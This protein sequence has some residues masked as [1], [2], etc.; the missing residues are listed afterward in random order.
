MI[1]S[2]GKAK[3]L[4]YIHVQALERQLVFSGSP[5]VRIVSYEDHLQ[6]SIQIQSNI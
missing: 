6:V 2:L 4:Y 5:Q 3:G 1:H